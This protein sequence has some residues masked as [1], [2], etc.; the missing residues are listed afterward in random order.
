MKTYETLYQVKENLKKYLSENPT[1]GNGA[2]VLP[3][4]IP[5]GPEAFPLIAEVLYLYNKNKT[6]DTLE[7]ICKLAI[8]M[9]PEESWVMLN[10]VNLIDKEFFTI[11][12]KTSG[13]IL[14]STYCGKNAKFILPQIFEKEDKEKNIFSFK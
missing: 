9:S 12:T 8:E 10:R 14:W 7:K 4:A 6:Q 5:E 13:W 2:T 11:W 1:A 3:E